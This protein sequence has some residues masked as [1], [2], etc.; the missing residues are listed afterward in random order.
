LHAPAAGTSCNTSLVINT[1]E[2]EKKIVVNE[3]V[4]K[5]RIT[6]RSKQQT[7]GRTLGTKEDA[8]DMKSEASS[9]RIC[10]NKTWIGH[11]G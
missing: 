5:Q 4:D 1:G 3:N 7:V 8:E 9:N 6:H 11:V 10:M 2:R